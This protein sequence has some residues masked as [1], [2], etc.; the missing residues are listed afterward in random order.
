MAGRLVACVRWR[1]RKRPN[2][3]DEPHDAQVIAPHATWRGTYDRGTPIT[4]QCLVYSTNGKM[5]APP[6]DST[7]QTG[8]QYGGV[9]G[10]G[11][12]NGTATHCAEVDW[13]S[14]YTWSARQYRRGY[15]GPSAWM[16]SLIFESRDA[17][18]LYYRRNRYYD[19][20]KARFT[21]EDPIGLAGGV[22]VYGFAEGDPVTYSDPLGLD[23]AGP[24]NNFMGSSSITARLNGK[25]SATDVRSKIRFSTSWQG[26]YDAWVR[27]QKAEFRNYLNTPQGRLMVVSALFGVAARGAGGSTLESGTIY[28]AGRTNPGNLTP[29]AGEEGLSFRNSLSNPIGSSQRP[30]FRPGDDYIA[31]D[32][33]R[34]PK[35]S[36]T[37]DDQ[38]PGHVT[39]RGTTPDEVRAAVIDRPQRIPR[40]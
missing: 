37:L 36:A 33:A 2:C 20:D 1:L 21:Q 27:H 7:P 23:C 10:G 18:G 5:L 28:R 22:N 30:V 9:V 29:R 34:L 17:S 4:G 40:D 19:S 13:P 3:S 15:N 31:V 25:C 38:P 35:G 8:D 26:R 14:A 6:P 32:V 24:F 16:G 11:T 39:V 12:Y